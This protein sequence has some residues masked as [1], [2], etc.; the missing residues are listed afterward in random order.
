MSKMVYKKNN[1]ILSKKNSKKYSKLAKKLHFMKIS[2]LIQLQL[3][4]IIILYRDSIYDF[5]S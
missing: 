1:V 3:R 4:K 2:R 5:M